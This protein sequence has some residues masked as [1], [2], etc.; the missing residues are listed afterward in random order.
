MMGSTCRPNL[1]RCTGNMWL[2]PD[3]IEDRGMEINRRGFLSAAAAAH[4]EGLL[5]AQTRSPARA[6]FHLGCVTYNLLKDAD[7][8]TIIATLETVGYAAVELRTQHKHGVE[9]SIE[10]AERTRVRRRFESSKVRL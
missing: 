2:E 6:D 7:L 9:P 5:C 8:E 1:P 3:A 10:A 4:A